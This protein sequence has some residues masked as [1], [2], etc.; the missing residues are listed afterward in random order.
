MST[1]MYSNSRDWTCE[2]CGSRNWGRNGKC[3]SCTEKKP[4]QL[5]NGDWFCPTCDAYMFKSKKSCTA[6]STTRPNGLPIV[7]PIVVPDGDECIVCL[8]EK[9]SITLV[10]GNGTGHMVV[11][12]T[13]APKLTSC[14]ICRQHIITRIKTFS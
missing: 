12:G 5:W 11:C 7:A 10:H 14:P 2:E 8:T 6:C 9:R 4:P 13:C 1:R 3:F